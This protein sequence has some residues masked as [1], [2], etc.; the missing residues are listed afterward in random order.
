MGFRP[1]DVDEMSLW[2]FACCSAGYR[3]AHSG[4]DARAPE[5]IEAATLA[6]YG[7]EGFHE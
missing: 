5:A 6:A 2:Q 3:R 7:V 4:E 1:R